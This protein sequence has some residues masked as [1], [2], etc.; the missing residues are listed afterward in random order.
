MTW[1]PFPF[2]ECP[3]C[4]Q[5]WTYSY[6]YDCPNNGQVE[7][8]PDSRRIRCQSCREK[9]SIWENKFICSCGNTFDSADVRAAIDDII[10]TASL[11]AMLVEKNKQEA[12]RARSLGENSLRVWIQGVAQ[13][14]GGYLGGLLGTIAGSLARWFVG[15]P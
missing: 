12:A 7:V 6:H 1:L 8:D 10:A 4:R 15:S 3:S 5:R 13:G 11:F 2:P 14:V 9:R